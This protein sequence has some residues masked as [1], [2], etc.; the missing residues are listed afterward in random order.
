MAGIDKKNLLGC[1]LI[2]LLA[3]A[4]QSQSTQESASGKSSANPQS[5]ANAQTKETGPT[6][7]Y[8]SATVLKTITRLVVI[9]VVATDKNGAVTD[10]DR[11]DFALLEDGKEQKIRVFNFQR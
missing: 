3:A 7:V 2:C 6:R 4:L 5:P 11:D 9:D 10:L 1:I 8:E